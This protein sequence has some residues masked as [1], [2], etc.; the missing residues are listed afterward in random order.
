VIQTA[1][2]TMLQNLAR[3]L[4]VELDL[5]RRHLVVELELEL[6]L[7]EQ[8]SLDSSQNARRQRQ[9]LG[10]RLRLLAVVELRLEQPSLD[11]SQNAR[12]QGQ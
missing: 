4:V 9:Q 5:L 12:Q 3:H 10:K 2:L 8:P 7:L 11:S 1:F 6:E